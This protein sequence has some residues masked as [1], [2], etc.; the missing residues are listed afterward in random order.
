MHI[1]ANTGLPS[2]G[3]KT[4]VNRVSVELIS[5]P[6]KHLLY[7]SDAISF[8]LICRNGTSVQLMAQVCS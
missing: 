4:K 2:Q 3:K 8:V 5:Y 7:P 1:Y 6:E